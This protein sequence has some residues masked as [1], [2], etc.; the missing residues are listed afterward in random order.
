MAAP[1]DD[2]HV[3]YAHYAAHCLYLALLVS[4]DCGD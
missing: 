2:K 4:S 1:K 3:K